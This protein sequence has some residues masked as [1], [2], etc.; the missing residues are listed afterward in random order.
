MGF[1][2]AGA[3]ILPLVWLLL[4]TKRENSVQSW[5]IKVAALLYTG[6]LPAHAILLRD[7]DDGKGWLFIAI[8]ATFAVDIAAYF[9][10][11]LVGRH[12]LAPSISPGKTW[13]GAAFGIAGGILGAWLVSLP[14]D[15]IVAGEAVV[16][17]LV[18]GVVAQLGDL[19]ESM[20]KRSAGVKDTGGIIPGHGGILDR[21][22]SLVFTVPVVYYFFIRGDSF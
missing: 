18:I 5:G 11:T 7:A 10:G 16:V 21:L 6:W 19:A 9:G 8:F 15:V 14:F 3:L 12:K 22:D 1:L 2:I 17:G 13:E 4:S 20:I